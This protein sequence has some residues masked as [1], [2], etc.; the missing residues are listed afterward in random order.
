MPSK[1]MTPVKTTID[2]VTR[3]PK[4]GARVNRGKA[5]RNITVCSIVDNDGLDLTRRDL[6]WSRTLEAWTLGTLYDRFWVSELL[7]Q[8]N[9]ELHSDVIGIISY[10]NNLGLGV[11]PKRTQTEVKYGSWPT[12]KTHIVFRINVERVINLK[13]IVGAIFKC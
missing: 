6:K 3:L 1:V 7:T 10:L 9:Q 13:K 5:R 11:L 4:Q 2:L 8:L 12:M